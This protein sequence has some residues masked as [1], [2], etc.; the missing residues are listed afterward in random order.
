MSYS[1]TTSTMNAPVAAR[2]SYLPL[3]LLCLG[4]FFID[5]YSSA[6]GAFQP[7]LVE[8]HH[9]RLAEAGLLG[10]ALVFS[11]SLAQP[12]YG[13]LS[14]RY[15]SKLFSCLA[16]A[17]AGIFISALGTASS[18]STLLI[19]VLLGGMGIASFHPQGSAWATIGIEE[20][21]ARWFAVFISS[22]TLG[23][24]LGPTF[25]SFFLPRIGLENSLWLAIPGIL[26]T[27]FL[28]FTL[29]PP[30]FEGIKDH[31]FDLEPLRK[32]WKTL[33][34]LYLLVF[35]RSIVQVTYAQLLPLYLT[36]ERGFTYTEATATLSLYL[37]T[38][39]LG[40][41]IGGSLA[42]RW[43]GRKVI[44]VSMS[45]C[46]PPLALFFLTTGWISIVSLALAGL[47]LLFTIPVNVV[48]AQQL[49]P[50]QSGTISALMM[51]FDWGLAGLIFIPLTGWV[52]DHYT[53]GTAMAFLAA[54]PVL[55]ALFA[56]MLP[57]E[58]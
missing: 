3:T 46:V 22:G 49:A 20:N 23:F 51:G 32:V 40:G 5:L 33:L 1:A 4:H 50:T 9:L 26:I 8:K 38:G 34:L 48:I 44:L 18:Y 11:A 43:G 47:I 16:P 42:D 36:K 25:F 12:L 41:F 55:G 53:L 39:A 10:G 21:K 2:F 37:A 54:F 28:M 45:C 27:I 31:K 57:K 29:S 58:I 19:V 35:V 30:S 56:W 15:R 14:D 24:A 6:L 13:Y 17:V 7:L 52:G